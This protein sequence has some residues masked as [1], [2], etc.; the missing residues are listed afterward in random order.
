M[1]YINWDSGSIPTLQF[2]HDSLVDSRI[3]QVSMTDSI[4]TDAKKQWRSL[5]QS[6]G[7]GPPPSFVPNSEEETK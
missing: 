4:R 5:V 6:G 3:T 2:L 1:R 7:G